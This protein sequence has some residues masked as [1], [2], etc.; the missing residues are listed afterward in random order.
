MPL[1]PG[2]WAAG[3]LALAFGGEAEPPTTAPPDTSS[4]AAPS[5]DSEADR[6]PKRPK[7]KRKG[8]GDDGAK[9]KDSPAPAASGEGDAA[10]R[11]G[12]GAR[13]EP[14]LLE[15]DAE[16]RLGGGALTGRGVHRNPAV[17]TLVAAAVEPSVH[18]GPVELRADLDLDH[19]ETWAVPL[20]QSSGSASLEGELRPWDELRVAAEAGLAGVARP[21][22]PDPYQPVDGDPALGLMPTDRGSFVDLWAQARLLWLPAPRHFVRARYRFTRTDSFNDPVFDALGR[23]NHLTPFDHDE[24][25]LEVSW[26]GSL[27][28]VR[29]GLSLGG[30]RRDWFFI[31]SRDA[32]TGL[33]HV[34]EGGDPPNPLQAENAL[35]AEPEVELELEK[36]QL[37]FKL[38][39]RVRL[40]QDP[41]QGYLS[42]LEQR[43]R[44]EGEWIVGPRDTALALE[45]KLGFEHKVYGDGA[46]A[47]GPGH[48]P[49]DWGDR[50]VARSARLQLQLRFPHRQPLRAFA[51]L[52]ASALLTN[53]PDYVAGVYPDSQAYNV[54][55]DHQH[56]QFLVGVELELGR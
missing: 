32:G 47:E 49:L 33:T 4:P 23:P 11:R 29:P 20:R 5:H 54:A 41:W 31:F 34:A 12:K 37:S 42:R 1:S 15:V 27:G 9:K 44:L 28:R 51:E 26:R 43:V 56:G 53:F 21:G 8:S 36:N 7:K 10:E 40:V 35:E 50:R 3:L 14:S 55:R 48:P 52:E 45:G 18:L 46:Y 6:V 19:E 13:K 39:W 38:A 2:L 22:W 25:A 17:L 30:A 16:A 24:H